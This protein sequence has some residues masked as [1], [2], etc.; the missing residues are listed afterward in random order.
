M[1]TAQEILKLSNTTPAILVYYG[2]LSEEKITEL[3]G[4][5]LAKM[6]N[7]G[8][9]EISCSDG[10]KAV[11]GLFRNALELVTG[12]T[13]ANNRIGESTGITGNGP[14]TATSVKRGNG[15]K[16]SNRSWGRRGPTKKHWR[17][18]L[19]KAY[20]TARW[21]RFTNHPHSLPAQSV[22]ASLRRM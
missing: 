9:W 13:D 1:A 8:Y 20:W 5:R 16:I 18:F 3:Q 7:C 11:D 22:G 10:Y 15:W 21:K 6:Y 17:R 4:V 19:T 2:Q 12:N 14:K